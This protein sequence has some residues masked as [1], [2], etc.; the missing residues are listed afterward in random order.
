VTRPTGRT[1]ADGVPGRVWWHLDSHR[2]GHTVAE[3]LAYHD[4]LEEVETPARGSARVIPISPPTE[5]RGLLG[6]LLGR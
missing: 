4:M 3:T 6:R 2:Y 5:R 1:T